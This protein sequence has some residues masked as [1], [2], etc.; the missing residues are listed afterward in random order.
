MFNVTDFTTSLLN[1]DDVQIGV[2]AIDANG[3]RTR[4]RSPHRPRRDGVA[5][6]AQP[7]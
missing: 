2:R 1:K 6:T 7:H 4:L 5:R 3:D